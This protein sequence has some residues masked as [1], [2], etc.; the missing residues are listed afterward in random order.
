M[1]HN[2]TAYAVVANPHTGSMPSCISK[3][4]SDY[5]DFMQCGYEILKSGT[6]R[7]CTEF[8][9]ELMENL[10]DSNFFEA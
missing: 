9:Q 10:V 2:L 1:N 5:Y 6:R 3:N 4:S 7:E 8:Y